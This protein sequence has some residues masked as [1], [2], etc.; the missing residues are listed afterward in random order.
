MSNNDSLYKDYF[1]PKR[2]KSENSKACAPEPRA[3][4]AISE[5]IFNVKGFNALQK[6]LCLLYEHWEMTLGEELASMAFPIGHRN[7][8]LLIAGEN[9]VAMNELNYSQE[10]I[11]DRV[12]AFLEEEYFE[13]VELHLLQDKMPLNQIPDTKFKIEHILVRP[14]NLGNLNLP[15][16]KVRDAYLHYLSLFEEENVKEN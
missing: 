2:S 5:D 6:K 16:G 9:S 8:I 10:E 3:F 14:E 1:R 15:E 4:N 11:L 7:K 13:S 12:H